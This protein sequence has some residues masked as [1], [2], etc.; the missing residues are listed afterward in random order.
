M[1]PSSFIRSRTTL[2]RARA[3][4]GKLTGSVV[5]GFWVS[6]QRGLLEVH[7]LGAVAEVVLRR[8]LDPVGPV[9]VI[10]EVEVALKDLVLGEG[11]LQLD[12]V[13]QLLDLAGVVLGGRRLGPGLVAGPQGVL[14]QGD[15]DVLLGER[16]ATAGDLTRGPV[17][18]ERPKNALQVSPAV[19]VEPVVLDGDLGGPHDRSDLG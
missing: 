7:R 2:R 10:D 5:P 3:L 13:F 19:L 4:S 12:G 17:G 6:Q 9:A 8:G 16:G 18:D 15:L 11:L 1:I 14:L